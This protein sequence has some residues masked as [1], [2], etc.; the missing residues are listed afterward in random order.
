MLLV[1]HRSIG[2]KSTSHRPSDFFR[3]WTAIGL[4]HPYPVLVYYKQIRRSDR[5]NQPPV[6][7]AREISPWETPV[8]GGLLVQDSLGSSPATVTPCLSGAPKRSPCGPSTTH[9]F[10]LDMSAP[11]SG[12]E[13]PEKNA[14]AKPPPW[15][16]QPSSSIAL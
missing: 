15:R 3:P 1:P 8:A 10:H 6:L 14:A 4:P 16:P 9:V 2:S 13:S 11:T 7:R 12:L 5:N